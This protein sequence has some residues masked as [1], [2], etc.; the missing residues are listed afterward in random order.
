MT[1]GRLLRMRHAVEA[2][3]LAERIVERVDSSAFLL[4][5]IAHIARSLVPFRAVDELVIP[6]LQDNY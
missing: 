1:H 6:T 2:V 5:L 3:K 4:I